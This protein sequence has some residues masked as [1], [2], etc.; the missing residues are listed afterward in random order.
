M[1]KIVIMIMMLIM[2]M[3]N[4]DYNFELDLSVI[5]MLSVSDFRAIVV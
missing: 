4:D 2:R 1:I 3:Y 5:Y